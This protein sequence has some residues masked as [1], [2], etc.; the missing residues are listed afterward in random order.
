MD[1]YGR[2]LLLRK[3]YDVAGSKPGNSAIEDRLDALEHWA[4]FFKMSWLRFVG[5]MKKDALSVSAAKRIV[6]SQSRG[7]DKPISRFVNIN[8]AWAENLTCGGR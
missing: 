7:T 5:R 8:G 4:G 2:V 1:I 6:Y 3:D